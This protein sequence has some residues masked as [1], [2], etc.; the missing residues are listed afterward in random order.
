MESCLGDMHLD[1]CIFYLDNI[2]IFS[3]T[4]QEHIGRLRGV[5]EK[6]W[7]AGL[8]LELNSSDHKYHT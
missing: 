4:P 2:I 1:W 7:V 5:F 8:K 6:L 3:K